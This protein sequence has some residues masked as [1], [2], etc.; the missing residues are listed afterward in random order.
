MDT[1]PKVMRLRYPHIKYGY[2]KSDQFFRFYNKG[3]AEGGC[4]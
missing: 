2:N 1:L 4:V 3:A